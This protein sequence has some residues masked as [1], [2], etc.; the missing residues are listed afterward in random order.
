MSSSPAGVVAAMALAKPV[1][2]QYAV[3]VVPEVDESWCGARQPHA[4]RDGVSR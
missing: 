3:G 2:V 4:C 1:G